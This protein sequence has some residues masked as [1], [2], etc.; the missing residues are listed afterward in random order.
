MSRIVVALGG[1]ALGDAPGE[2]PQKVVEVA[3][4]VAPLVG[5][6]HQVILCYGDAP[7]V[8]LIHLAFD[9]AHH[10]TGSPAM[11]L[12]ECTSMDEGYM[13]FHLAQSIDNELARICP[14]KQPTITMLTQ[15]IV[16]EDDPAFKDPKKLIG[17]YYPEEEARKFMEETGVQYVNTGEKG[18]RRVV[19]SPKPVGFCEEDTLKALLDHHDM[20]IAA[21]GGGI[22]VVKDDYGYRGVPAVIDK[23]FAAAKLAEMLDADMLLIL[24]EAHQVS[25]NEGTPEEQK[26]TEW[27]TTEAQ[28]QLE[29]L[30]QPGMRNKVEAAITFA[31]SG[32]GRKAVIANVH[33]ALDAADGRSGTLIQ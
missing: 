28:K 13:G 16:D 7:Q 3:K 4:A 12:P 15:A 18:W 32:L 33:H 1:S 19:A 11:E 9:L 30:T 22:P 23:D 29:E 25:L 10:R 20:I 27:T 24:A 5:A 6:G 17:E 21:G 14:Q 8:G 2:Q 26:L 31:G